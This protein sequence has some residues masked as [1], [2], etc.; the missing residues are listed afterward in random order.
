MLVDIPCILS[1]QKGK[2][3]NKYFKKI[4][5]ISNKNVV[6]GSAETNRDLIVA[7]SKEL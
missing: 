5:E 2:T 6:N 1:D 7:A 4:G 3:I